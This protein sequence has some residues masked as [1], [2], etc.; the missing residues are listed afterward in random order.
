MQIGQ[1][2]SGYF[3]SQKKLIIFINNYIVYNHPDK[4]LTIV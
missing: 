3:V 2:T 1:S 4:I